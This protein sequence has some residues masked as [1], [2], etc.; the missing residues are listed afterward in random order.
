MQDDVVVLESTGY[1]N[2]T[3]SSEDYRIE[4]YYPVNDRL[5]DLATLAIER[6]ISKQISLDNII[7]EFAAQDNNRRITLT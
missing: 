2:C 4:V 6:K 5:S 7:Q 1:R 3:G